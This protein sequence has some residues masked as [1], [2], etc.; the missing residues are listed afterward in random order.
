MDFAFALFPYI[1]SYLWWRDLI[2]LIKSFKFLVKLKLIK[3]LQVHKNLIYI[4]LLR[5]KNNHL[6]RVA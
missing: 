5:S 4:R 3:K 6:G 1:L 2:C